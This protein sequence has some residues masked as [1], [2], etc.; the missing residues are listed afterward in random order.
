MHMLDE[1]SFLLAQQ[2]TG[3]KKKLQYLL[4]L[5]KSIRLWHIILF[6]F[7]LGVGSP[8]VNVL[9]IKLRICILFYPVGG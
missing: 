2:I 6:L 8:W 9:L 5:D 1:M 4:F 3:N 7:F